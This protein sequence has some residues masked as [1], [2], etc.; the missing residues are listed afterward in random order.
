MAVKPNQPNIVVIMSDEQS[1]DTLRF[2]GNTSA[3][4]PHLDALAKDGISL[5]K[6]YTPYPLCCPARTSLWSGRMPHDHHV[7]GNWRH[8]RSEIADGG[9]VNRF[10]DAGYHTMYTG[11][12]HVPG[13]T[14]ARFGFSDLA[15]IPAKPKG[16]DRGRFILEYREYAESQGYSL[17]PDN[18]ENLTAAD[19]ELLKQPGKAPCGRAEIALEHY[20]EVWQTRQF[21][22]SM[23]RREQDRP[24]FAVCSYNAPHFPM[25]VPAPYDTLINP[26]DIVLPPNFLKG[27]DGKPGEVLESRYYKHLEHCDESEWRRFIAHYLGFCTLIDDQ[28]GVITDY[29]KQNDLYENTIVV[30]V[31]D[32]G[33][34]MGAH[35]LVEKGFYLHYDEALRVPLI[36]AGAGA[37]GSSSEALVQLNDLIPTLADLAGV[38]IQTGDIDGRSFAG[39]VQGQAARHRDYVTAETFKWNG[40]ENG[41]GEY[42]PLTGFNPDTDSVNLSIRTDDWKYIFRYRD[43]EELYDMKA[44]PYENGNAAGKPEH[45]GQLQRMRRLLYEELKNSSPF[46]AEL[47]EQRLMA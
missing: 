20:L 19:A 14:P 44:D 25:V 30:F 6:C 41:K 28:V 13:T 23:E 9:L 39:V 36:I 42:T 26:E 18:I 15:A 3:I 21:L 47:L 11:K 8:I 5:D 12:W 38:S 7:M 22:A 32:H 10:R 40:E 45:A 35:G 46:L 24:F 34:M 29:L 27:T 43:I 37:A 31:S 16:I 2:H 17:L 1:W 4:T 33:D